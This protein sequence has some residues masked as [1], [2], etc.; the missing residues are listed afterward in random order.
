MLQGVMVMVMI[1][2]VTNRNLINSLRGVLLMSWWQ[3]IWLITVHEAWCL[4]TVDSSAY[5]YET[6]DGLLEEWI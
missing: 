4:S 5:E 2:I 3:G 6:T 1:I